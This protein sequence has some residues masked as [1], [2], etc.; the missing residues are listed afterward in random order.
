MNGVENPAS[1]IVHNAAENNLKNIRK[2]FFQ[3]LLEQELQSKPEQTY[4]GTNT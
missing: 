4:L 1:I 2:V 3:I